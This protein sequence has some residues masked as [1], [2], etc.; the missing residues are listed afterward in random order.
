[1]LNG[2]EST[3]CQTSGDWNKETPTCELGNKIDILYLFSEFL[4]QF[5]IPM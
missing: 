5:L 4:Y 3:I 2:S 1:M